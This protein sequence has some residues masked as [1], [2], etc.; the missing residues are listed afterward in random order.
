VTASRGRQLSPPRYRHA[1][2]TLLLNDR[3]KDIESSTR[4]ADSPVRLDYPQ[5]GSRPEL[6]IRAWL[7]SGSTGRLVVV[8][9]VEIVELALNTGDVIVA[10]LV[11][12]QLPGF[13]PH[14]T[15]LFGAA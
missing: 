3:K 14:C 2:A 10:A 9:G 8:V 12:V 5:V 4:P 11:S 15:G 13:P 1:F 6:S 7:D